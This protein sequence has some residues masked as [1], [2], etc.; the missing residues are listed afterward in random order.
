MREIC[1]SGSEG[2]ETGLTGLPYP[3]VRLQVDRIGEVQVLV[4]VWV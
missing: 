3:Y 4:K 2:G 1:Q